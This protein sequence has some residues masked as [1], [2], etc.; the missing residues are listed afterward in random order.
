MRTTPWFETAD[1]RYDW[2]NRTVCVGSG[3]RRPD[4]VEIDFFEVT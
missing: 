2:M 4:R 3:A 1:K